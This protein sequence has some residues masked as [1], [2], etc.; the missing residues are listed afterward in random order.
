MV[1]CEECQ[2]HGTLRS[3]CHAKRLSAAFCFT[4]SCSN[5]NRKL[6]LFRGVASRFAPSQKKSSSVPSLSYHS[7]FV[8]P[9]E[10]LRGCG[11]R[12]VVVLQM[13]AEVFGSLG[14][15]TGSDSTGVWEAALSRRPQNQGLCF[16]LGSHLS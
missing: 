9:G 16:F 7:V 5:K 15:G 12:V 4:F 11:H 13:P 14:A 10:P 3:T 6:W 2:R 1:F 8:S